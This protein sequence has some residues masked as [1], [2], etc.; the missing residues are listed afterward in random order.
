MVLQAYI[1]DSWDEDGC[2]VLAGYVASAEEWAA[3]SREWEAMLPR[4]TLQADGHYRFKMSEMAQSPER[5]SRVAGFHNVINKHVRMSIAS[6]LDLKDHRLA[7]E[8][9]RTPFPT[10]TMDWGGFNSPFYTAFRCLMDGF[11]RIRSDST[12]P[13]SKYFKTLPAGQPVDF[14]FDDS[15][16]K[17]TVLRVWDEYMSHRGPLAKELYGSTPRFED[18]ERFLP[19]QAADFRAY[20][21]REW[22]TEHGVKNAASGRFPFKSA[23]KTIDNLIF[24]V[25]EDEMADALRQSF[26][27]EHPGTYIVDRARREDPP[28]P[29]ERL[30]NRLFRRKPPSD[31]RS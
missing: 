22:A 15:T 29:L 20:W 10:I 14:Y 9:Y 30:F 12:Q 7:L 3:F 2:Y 28:A 1:D 19:I 23:A 17:G 21:V 18:D 26:E 16:E 11:H 25:S 27:N 31:G 24:S 13:T 6:V 4:A 8:R 5:M